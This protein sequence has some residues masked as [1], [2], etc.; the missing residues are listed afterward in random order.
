[1]SLSTTQ[2]QRRRSRHLLRQPDA[3]ILGTVILSTALVTVLVYT[4]ATM[5][6]SWAYALRYLY[7]LPIILAAAFWGVGA[8]MATALATVSLFTPLLAPLLDREGFSSQAIE[9]L[10]SIV[11]FNVLAYVVGQL[12]GVQRRQKELYRTLD[13]LGAAFSRELDLDELLELILDRVMPLLSATAAEV[14]LYDERERRLRLMASR[15]LPPEL[16][17]RARER[18]PD[19]ETLADWILRRN[20]PFLHNDLPSDSR[21]RWTVDRSSG[22]IH[23]ML[24]VPLRRGREPFGLLCVYNKVQG[25]FEQEDLDL[26]EA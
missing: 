8:G 11:L 10:T 23:T 3:L 21:Y 4:T 15:G 1:M 12:A 13:T 24:A 22:F 20:Q 25:G 9:M 7:L 19:R 26:L 16:V 6:V 2:T 14:L 18:P 5:G 17:Q